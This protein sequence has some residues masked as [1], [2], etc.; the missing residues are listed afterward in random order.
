LSTQLFYIFLLNLIINSHYF[1]ARHSEFVL[2]N[3]DCEV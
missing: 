2:Y 3:V 1:H